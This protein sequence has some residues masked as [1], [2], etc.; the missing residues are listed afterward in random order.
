MK[1]GESMRTQP[2]ICLD[3]GEKIRCRDSFVS[4][5][6]FLIGI[7]AT[8]AVRVVTLLDIHNPLYGKMAWYIGV[9]GFF[10][11]FIYKFKIESSRSRVIKRAKISH[12]IHNHEKLDPDDYR[13]IGSILCSL[14]SKKDLINYILI[15]STSI[16][17][18]LAAFY[19]DF[20]N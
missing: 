17:A 6:F 18:L 2:K 1:T 10:I 7:I 12:K 3:C 13:L 11:F 8:I 5:I 9:A 20:F 15:F 16:L 4:W 14:T 19:L